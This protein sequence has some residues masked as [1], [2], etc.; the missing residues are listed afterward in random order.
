VTPAEIRAELDTLPSTPFGPTSKEAIGY[1]MLSRHLTLDEAVVEFERLVTSDN[2]VMWR[3]A[4][5]AKKGQG[6]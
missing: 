4:L 2:G 5:R 6:T 3:A 1:L